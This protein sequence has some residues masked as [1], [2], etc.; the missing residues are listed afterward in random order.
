[1]FIE[2]HRSNR[3]PSTVSFGLGPGFSSQNFSLSCFSLHR[4]LL[5]PHV[6]RIRIASLGRRDGSFAAQAYELIGE[7]QADYDQHRSRVEAFAR[8]FIERHK[9]QQRGEQW[10][11]Q[12]QRL[13]QTGLQRCG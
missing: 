7:T 3:I 4:I 2:K 12:F 10:L 11:G 13:M 8:Y 6:I 9:R 1:M 5:G